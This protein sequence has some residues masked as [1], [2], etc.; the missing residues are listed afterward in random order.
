MELLELGKNPISE[1][2][3]AGED[4]RYEPEFEALENEIGKMTSLSATEGVDWS[5]VAKLCHEILSD[6]S[7]NLMA[8]IYLCVALLETEG[9]SGFANG[10]HV[11]RELLDNFWD[12][13][14]PPKKRMR[15]CDC[16]VDGKGRCGY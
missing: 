4:V 13:M 3:P 14:F 16:M 12:T 9:L 8:A 5:K 1:S 10:V 2:S 7:K 15:E 6:K 11:L